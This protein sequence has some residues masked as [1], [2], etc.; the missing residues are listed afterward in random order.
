MFWYVAAGV[1]WL[2]MGLGVAWL[3][4]SLARFSEPENTAVYEAEPKEKLEG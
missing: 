4:G 1:A 2:V 3:W